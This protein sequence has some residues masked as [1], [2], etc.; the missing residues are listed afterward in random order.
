NALADAFVAQSVAENRRILEQ[1][2][3]PLGQRIQGT[4]SVIK[5]ETPQPPRTPIGPRTR[6]NTAA[7]LVLGLVFG[8]LVTFGIEYFEDVLRTGR[9]TTRALNLPVLAA[10]AIPRNRRSSRM[11]EPMTELL[12][13]DAPLSPAAEAYRALRAMLRSGSTTAPPPSTI[14]VCGI[15]RDAADSATVAA[16]L[17]ATFAVAGERTLLVDADLRNP[18][19]QRLA[20][21]TITGGLAEW[22]ENA[23]D[24][25]APVYRTSL[26]ELAILPAG[27]LPPGTNPADR[28]GR[29]LALGHLQKLRDLAERVVVH[30]PPLPIFG[31]ALTVAGT[32]DG[33]LLVVRSGVTPRT[34]AQQAKEQLVRAGATVLG[35]VLL[36]GQR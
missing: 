33:V 15:G 10:F 32:V 25:D 23:A 28:L 34:A 22:L 8:V 24:R 5:L 19:L 14:L 3:D 6:L 31:D 11:E 27:A 35:V 12:V 7:A 4:V 13:V 29:A 26:P 20:T 21:Q 36:R 16:N 2:R 1:F 9:D 17:A 18:S 30:A